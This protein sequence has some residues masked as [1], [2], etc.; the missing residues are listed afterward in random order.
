MKIDNE[1][2]AAKVRLYY[3]AIP[4][5]ITLATG[6]VYLIAGIR[7]FIWLIIGVSLLAVVFIIMAV[8]RFQYVVIFASP[9]KLTIRFKNLSPFKTANH[10]IEMKA[11]EFAGYEFTNSLAGIRKNLVVFK[12]TPGGKAKF[13]LVSMNLLK[14]EEIDKLKRSFEILLALKRT[15]S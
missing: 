8:L 15:Q 12:S 6:S 13:P 14:P 7:E 5:I 3:M 10:A 4:L 11:N 2:I 9:E 1:P